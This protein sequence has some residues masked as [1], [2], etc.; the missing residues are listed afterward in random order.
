MPAVT[1]ADLSA[2]APILGLA[3]FLDIQD[4]PL[5]YCIAPL[6]LT[7]PNATILPSADPDFDGRAF[8]TLDP[9]F[10][11]VSPISFG[12]GGT[13]GVEF[14]LSGSLEF[15]ADLLTA[16]SDPSRFFGRIAKLWLIRLNES[17]QPTHAT[18][19]F[20]GYMSVPSF[21]GDAESQ[22]ILLRAE[23]YLAIR[24]GSPSRSLLNQKEFD[25][26]D[27]SAGATIGAARGT[28]ALGPQWDAVRSGNLFEGGFTWQL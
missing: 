23:S 11:S 6:P 1:D 3:A 8:T 25:P 4:D 19:R 26:D 12:P 15:D 10:I 21:A 18:P 7:M 9:R 16:L 22:T 14:Q 20:V 13:D 5:R 24:V 2:P 28:G 17:Y 27:E